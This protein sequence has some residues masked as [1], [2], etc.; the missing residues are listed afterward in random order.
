M[1]Y[2]CAGKY[3]KKKVLA[4]AIASLR[5]D[6]KVALVARAWV[7]YFYSSAG[8]GGADGMTL[9]GAVVVTDQRVIVVVKSAWIRKREEIELADV[10]DIK[11]G[12][13]PNRN[14]HILGAATYQNADDLI[15]FVS[16]NSVD[17][18]DDSIRAGVLFHT[19]K[20]KRAQ[21]IVDAIRTAVSVTQDGQAQ[22]KQPPGESPVVPEKW[23]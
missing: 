20:K 19:Y 14:V 18:G 2:P 5:A 1:A 16:H 4:T 3:P 8:T 22:I 7:T 21:Q 23:R 17:I 9:G 11:I 10:R 6:E 13:L 12:P 15:K